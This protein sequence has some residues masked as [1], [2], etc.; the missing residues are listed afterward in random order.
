[1]LRA[2]GAR[3]EHRARRSRS[4]SARRKTSRNSAVP[5]SS[6]APV[7]GRHAE[8]AEQRA[9]VGVLSRRCGSSS[10]RCTYTSISRAVSSARSTY[11]PVQY[12]VSAIRLSRPLVIAGLPWAAPL[13][14]STATSR[15][16][17]GGE[18]S[19]GL[20]LIAGRHHGRPGVGRFGPA[21]RDQHPGVLGPAALAG[22]DHQLALGQRD[23]GQA[24][25]QHP[26]VVAVVDRERAQVDVPGRQLLADRAP[27]RWTG[28]PAAARSSP[29]G[30]AATRAR[31]VSRVASSACGPMTMPAAA[32]AVHRLEHQLVQVAEHP[33]AAVRG[34]RAGRTPRCRSSGS[35]LR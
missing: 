34:R 14:R 12:S 23:P 8:D 26:D 7:C 19:G 22:V 15:G 1:M 27:A 28:P 33:V 25:G 31:S 6:R 17:A 29:A 11:R 2:P 9:A 20:G 10:I 4:G 35:S 30:C 5:M 32:R 13:C 24:A 21:G 3:A 16:S 18:A